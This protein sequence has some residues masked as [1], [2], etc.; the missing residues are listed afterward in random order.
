MRRL[1][2]FFLLGMFSLFS[3]CGGVAF[4]ADSDY[5]SPS[6]MVAD[7]SGQVIY[8][9]ENTANQI[10]VLDVA[11]K[12]TTKEIA[13]KAAPNGLAL[14]ADGKTLYA[15]CGG[16]D[17]GMVAMIDTAS[18]N[19]TGTVETGHTP[20]APVLSPDG[21]TLYV[22]Y[23][24]DNVVA[25]IDLGSKKETGQV[26]MDREP[27]A[28]AIT[29][30]GKFLA[31]A[32]HL[33][34]DPANAS[35]VSSTVQIIDTAA[36]KSVA[37]AKLP[38][39]S[40]GL[41]GIT[42]SP[43]GKY[44]VVTHILGRYQLPT[45]QLERGWMNTNAFTIIDMSSKE[46]YNTVLLD[47]VDRGAANP[48]GVTMSDDGKFL[49][50]THAG[51]HEVSVIDWD[52][53]MQ[54][55]ADADAGKKVTEV[56]SSAEDVRNDLAF[57]VGVRN[58]VQLAGNGPRDVK[59]VGDMVFATEYFSDSISWFKLGVDI[60]HDVQQ[61]KMNPDTPITDARLGQTFFND[62][63]FCFQQW[64]SC[65]SCHPDDRVDGLNWDLLNDGI[66]NPK[67]TKSMLLSHK[68][69]PVMMTG[70]RASA[71]VAVR[72]GIKFIQF[73]VRPEEDAE[74]I[75]TYLKSLEPV[76]SPWLVNGKLSESAERGKKIFD[77]AGCNHCHPAPLY[78]NMEK[79]DV[80]TGTGREEGME[81]DTPTL[82]EVWRTG[83][84]LYDGRA[85]T[86]KDVLTTYNKDD[87]HGQTSDLSEQ[88]LN[89]LIEYVMSL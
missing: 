76:P 56:T 73:A 66:G 38:D 88:E 10:A 77:S 48:W 17:D 81:F 3:L 46:P 49:C 5:L 34:S 72:A 23:R 43:D 7:S 26:E 18:G 78:T 60:F 37:H 11:S 22:C 64:Q 65:A 8:I 14:S 83:P 25:M 13:L 62:G 85:A 41:R 31:V 89:D 33:P 39:G 29:P 50:V 58:R 61:L 51:S 27:V 1:I 52:A 75:D 30:D 87:E 63:A 59:V 45:T 68:T 21:K 19:V 79:Y 12:K 4:A 20:M 36:G 67:N 16:S 24:F 28:A 44:A 80:G 84:Y 2:G 9:A 86:M 57:L 6:A 42:M 35:Y 53:L 32:N 55:L 82:V 74:K 71:E 15:T 47:N 54:R 40:T 69:P 70:V